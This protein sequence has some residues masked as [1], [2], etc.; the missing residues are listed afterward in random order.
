M[1]KEQEHT[2][3]PRSSGADVK[4]LALITV[5]MIKGKANEALNKMLLKGTGGN[6]AL[7][8]SFADK[9]NAILKGD[10]PQATQGL[11]FGNPKFAEEAA[12]DSVVEATSC[13]QDF[14]GNHHHSPMRT[15]VRVMLQ[16]L[17]G[18]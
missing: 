4:G 1:Q 5:D 6:R 9:Y 14:S 16:T 7:L 13:E 11:Q 8:S 10:I 2:R 15:I 3:D 18:P 12:S 17:Q